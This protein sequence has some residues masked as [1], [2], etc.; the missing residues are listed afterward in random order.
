MLKRCLFLLLIFSPLWAYTQENAL[1]TFP[2][3][4]VKLLE[5]PFKNAQEVDKQ[6]LLE[7]NP[8]RL[9]A[10]FYLQ[11]GL[12]PKSPRYG[13]WE[14]TGLD[15]HIG[16]H[17]L[18]ALSLMYAST[19]SQEV[20]YRLN[21]MLEG[22]EECQNQDPDGYVGG[23]PEGKKMWDQVANGN[24]RAGGFS[25]NDKWVP[26]YNIH[27]LFAGLADA[28]NYT[29]SKKAKNILSKL[30]YWF[31]D[32]TDKLND[33]QIQEI[34]KS[35]HGGINEVFVDVAEITGDDQFLTLANRLSHQVLLQPLMAGKDQLNGMHANTQIPKI[36]G[37]FRVS[38][39][40][41]DEGLEN[42]AQYFWNTVVEKRT[43]SIGGNSVREHFHPSDN[44]TEMLTSREGP[45][46]CNTYNM[47]KLS[48]YLFL[49]N[50]ELKYMDYYERALYN[51]ILSSQHP[52]HGGFVYFTPMRPQHYRVYSNP[53]ETFWCCVGSGMENHG[54]YGEMIY[55][56]DGENIFVNLFIPSELNW[57]EKG[58]QLTQNTSFPKSEKSSLT[59]QLKKKKK[60]ALYIRKPK[61]ITGNMEIRVNGQKADYHSIHYGYIKIERT[62]KDEDQVEINL[63]METQLEYLPDGSPWASFV[64]GPIVLAAKT[65]SSDLKG[66]IADDSRMGHIASG[67][68]YS[69]DNLPI[70]LQNNKIEDQLEP[71]E[72]KSLQFNLD[73][74]VDSNRHLEL[75]PFYQIHDSRY[76]LY[77][78]VSKPE[79]IAQTREW[80][81]DIEKRSL[82][83][84]K[85]TVDKITPGEQ[86]PES[87][88]FFMDKSSEAGVF[89]D[90][91][92]RKSSSWF[93]YQLRNG[94]KQA[95]K[96]RLTIHTSEDDFAFDIQLNGETFSTVR[97]EKLKKNEF[98]NDEGR[99]FEVDYEL[100]ENLG[101]EKTID[102]KFIAKENLSTA[103]I[104]EIRLLK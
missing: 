66:I 98:F 18:S 25:L 5:S 31:L 6:Y 52:E 95:K 45:E 39:A 55:A 13:N 83:L 16:G 40:T 54:K 51:H 30:S 7:M 3:N 46:T 26:I 73:P 8:D 38:Q 32:L 89:Q 48:K 68:L 104:F 43:V 29:G 60:F 10:P 69:M 61:W 27:K 72:G 1:Q 33:L 44:F 9:L 34:L 37:F 56:H 19:G 78:P 62:W 42:A 15:G 47:V 75:E 93:G 71:I 17:Y 76:I 87:D 11:A 24:I 101:Q 91:H 96:L 100:P 99:F 67:S 97:S 81:T 28:Y 94:Q 23:I 102:L 74:V 85:Q 22:L 50:P 59:L 35:E 77:F 80:L 53:H 103:K 88:H 82:E 90:R 36:I 20:L 2:L 70:L 14:N 41:G 64:H 86:Q 57:E 92:Y 79:E 4:Q 84:E 63:P 12:E 65:D 21:Y 58:I 49:E